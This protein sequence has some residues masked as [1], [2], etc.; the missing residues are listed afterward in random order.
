LLAGQDLKEEW[1]DVRVV[2]TWE[3]NNDDLVCDICRPLNGVEVEIDEPFVNDETGDEFDCP[4]GHVNCRC[5]MDS[6]TDILANA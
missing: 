4:P 5:W 3:T 2:K 6:T 1:P